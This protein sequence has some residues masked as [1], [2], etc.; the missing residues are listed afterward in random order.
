[1]GQ[2]VESR[3]REATA[4]ST[5][6]RSATPASRTSEATARCTATPETARRLRHPYA[7]PTPRRACQASA[8]TGQTTNAL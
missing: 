5:A 1:M 8:G 4:A 7:S 2:R 6:D 3:A